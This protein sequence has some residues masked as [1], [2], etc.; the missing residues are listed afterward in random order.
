MGKPQKELS[1]Y[2]LIL[3]TQI[4][5]VLNGL[6][7]RAYLIQLQFKGQAHFSGAGAS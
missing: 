4:I 3:K 5:T 1:R 7:I 6:V 2:G